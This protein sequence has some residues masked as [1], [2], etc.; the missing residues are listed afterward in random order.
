MQE[1]PWLQKKKNKHHS[2]PKDLG[3]L[4]K[5]GVAKGGRMPQGAL[6]N[7]FVFF[8]FGYVSKT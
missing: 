5:L 8:G 2:S 7:H 6:P 4:V 3:F 1:W